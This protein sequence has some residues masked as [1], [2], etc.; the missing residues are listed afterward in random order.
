MFAFR[1]TLILVMPQLREERGLGNEE[2]GLLIS[3]SQVSY[4]VGK[5]CF[6]VLSDVIPAPTLLL[7]SQFSAA[8]CFALLARTST[9]GELKFYVVALMAAQAPHAAAMAKIV[10]DRFGSTGYAFSCINA[11]LS[12]SVSILE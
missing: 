10:G 2:V 7:A 8:A 12:R 1:Q 4:M 11:S 5:P 3:L 6:Q 9:Y